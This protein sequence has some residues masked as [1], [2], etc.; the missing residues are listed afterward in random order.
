MRNRI[1]GRWIRSAL[2]IFWKSNA[3]GKTANCAI[4]STGRRVKAIIPVHILGHPVNME[5]ILELAHKFSL[6][7]IEDATE[8]LG[9]KYEDHPTGS[10]AD[11]ACF[12]FNGNKI[13]T[14]GGGGMIMTDNEAW[15]RKAK[16]LTTQAKD[17][18]V[19]YIHNEI[20]YNYR[21]TNMQAAMGC[22]QLE[23][24]DDYVVKKRHIAKTYIEAFKDL[25]GITP[26]RKAP[27]A[28]SNFWMFT[29][30]I[31]AKLFGKTSRQ[32]RKILAEKKIQS[33]PL[34]QPLHLSPH[35]QVASRSNAKPPKCCTRIASACRARWD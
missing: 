10:L 32:L 33:R 19:E 18:P 24:L 22:A 20:G 11:I 4:A 31:D 27:W 13:I 12:S 9:A 35:T 1:I 7:V 2:R 6:L 34:W 21:L 28:S 15:A 8:S 26:M 30:L 17:D 5:P 14:T 23:Q 16:Y 25:P 3:S 29:V